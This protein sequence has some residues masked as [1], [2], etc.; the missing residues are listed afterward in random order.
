MTADGDQWQIFAASGIFLFGFTYLYVG[1]VTLLNVDTNGIGWYSLW[2]AI[3]ACGYATVNLFYFKDIKFGIIWLMWAILWFMFFLLL[4][5]KKK[6]SRL[7]GWVTLIMSW[8][9]AT[10]P[11]FLI[12]IDVWK[13]ISNA[14]FLVLALLLIIWFVYLYLK[15]KGS[16]RQS[17]SLKT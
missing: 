7:T 3:A 12:L 2:V 5:L 15:E 1:I 11:A 6:I 4:G 9:T 10:L 17:P 8:F 13:M 16:H 14:L